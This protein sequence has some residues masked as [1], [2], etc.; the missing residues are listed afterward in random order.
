MMAE[1]KPTE[2]IATGWTNITSV[3]LDGL[4]VMKI[5]KHCHENLPLTV[6]GQLLGMDVGES[7]EITN[8]YSFPQIQSSTL[9]PN[10]ADR[11]EADLDHSQYQMNMMICVRNV[12]IDHQVVGWYQSSGSQ[13]GSF[14]TMQWIDTQFSYQDNLQNVVCLV[15]DP[16]RTESG[17]LGI[18]AYR[19]SKAFVEM[20][21]RREFTSFAFSRF[22][23][24]SS[25]I[26]EEVPID[27]KMSTLQKAYIADLFCQPDLSA[28]NSMELSRLSIAEESPLERT[29][30]F[31]ANDLEVLNRE[32][33]KY[34]FFVRSNSARIGGLY[35]D[36]MRARRSGKENN[37][38]NP[39]RNE[40][41]KLANAMSVETPRLESKMLIKELNLYIE[42]LTSLSVE[43]VI[44]ENAVL[45]LQMDQ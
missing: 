37:D 5:I 16:V 27:L 26:I 10:D 23:M 42:K 11:G 12:N 3:Q 7:L 4:V 31:M 30:E 17:T 43:S 34:S 6:T 32:Q 22:G 45:S 25:H 15:Y 19:L 14:L 38:E 29:L 44:K 39:G 8:S 13:M 40:M 28:E 21:K 18:R 36:L 33:H 1:E 9:G 2:A 35:Q 20:R 41:D 24:D